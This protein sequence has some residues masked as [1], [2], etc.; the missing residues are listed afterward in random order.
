MRRY[1]NNTS[2]L[3]AY[4]LINDDL[5]AAKADIWRLRVCVSEYTVHIIYIY[6]YI[7]TSLEIAQTSH[8]RTNII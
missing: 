7:Y 4:N 6:I 8:V 3:W 5:G 2:L 1:F